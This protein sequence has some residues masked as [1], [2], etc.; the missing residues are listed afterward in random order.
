MSCSR[1]LSVSN[2]LKLHSLMFWRLRG[3]ATIRQPSEFYRFIEFIQTGS[4]IGKSIYFQPMQLFLFL[5]IIL[6]NRSA[7][8]HCVHQL[9]AHFVFQAQCGTGSNNSLKTAACLQWKRWQD[10][11]NTAESWNIKQKQ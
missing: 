10:Y 5:T 4:V 7:L 2:P 9:P 6:K 1:L 8:L 11:I 3:N